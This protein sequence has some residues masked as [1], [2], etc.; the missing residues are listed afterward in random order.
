MAT[1][2]AR[3]THS[4]SG[5]Y[6]IE[7]EV[8]SGG[9]ATVYLAH[10]VR[11][12][13]RVALKVLRSE[14]AAVI[15]AERFLHEIKTTANLQHPHILALFDSGEVDGTVFYVMPYVEGESL[16]DRLNRE[17]QLPVDEA[18]RIAREVADALDYAHRHGVVHR[19]IKP[20]NI[21]LH[22][23]R[24]V[25][26]DFG[27]ALAVSRSD[28]A[29]R[30]TETG[31]SL[32]T[33]H[34]MSPEQ[35]MG[36]REVTSRSDV[37]A[38]GCVLYEMLV[39]EPPF[40]GPSAQAIV[41]RVVTE[42][43]RSLT[44][45]RHTIPPHVDAAVRR[46]LEKLP[47]DRFKSSAQFAEAL[48]NPS[49]GGSAAHAPASH[50]SSGGVLSRII[51]NP[52]WSWGTAMA[53]AAAAIALAT[54]GVL[55]RGP[56]PTLRFDVTL[57][58]ASGFTGSTVVLVSPD[59]RSVITR[60]IVGQR[61]ILIARRLD[62]L[63]ST[64]IPGSIGAERPFLSPDGASI[65]YSVNG[66][67]V[68]LPISGGTPVP[69]GETTWGGGA[70]NSDG[71][72]AFTK[73]YQSGLFLLNEAGGAERK[74]TDP[75]SSKGELAHWWPQWLP[76]G[77]SL[78]FTAYRSPISRA[79]IEVLDV[80]SGARKVI[81]EGGSMPKLLPTG[82]LLFVRDETVLAVGFDAKK[83]ETVG[84]PTVVVEDVFMNFSD[85][86]ASWD[87]SPNG[88]L[89]YIAA[90]S[91]GSRVSV[92]EVDRRGNER[93]VIDV[94]DRYT[95]PRWAPDGRRISVTHAAQRSAQD[96]WVY[97]PA[98]ANRVRITS[99]EGQD[100][101]A[102]WSPDGRELIFMSER[103]LFELHRKSSDASRPSAPF[104]GGQHDR[105]TG[106]V[107][108]DGILAFVL[109]APGA[110]EIWTAPLGDA[111]RATKYLTTGFTLGHPALAPTGRWM[112]YDSNEGGRLEVFIQSYPDPTRD[113]IQVSSGGGSEPWWT[114]GGRELAFRRG[115]SVM[116]VSVD[117]LTGAA[118]RPIALFG[119]RYASR[120]DWAVPASYDVT[121]D[122][123]RFL[124]LKFAAGEER[125]RV[126]VVTNWFAELRSKV[127]R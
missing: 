75:D 68:K 23:G 119:G 2:L 96:V 62:S 65:A 117:P 40:T 95:E 32:G 106:N 102:V 70:W 8:G 44:G 14:L 113:R 5:R 58:Q 120:E 51:R 115:D 69:F 3:L 53:L 80:E 6:R 116:V 125:R 77:K 36:E 122:G 39:G 108:P 124:M 86:H 66:K 127:P 4:L 71:R 63:R 92:V 73:S 110:T 54:R 46:A 42:S 7:R 43:P 31:M 90:S 19:D 60:A 22:D 48:V 35:A 109:A 82:H 94:P 27:I 57:D 112:A 61:P 30:M 47:A 1:D 15:G 49:S 87:V 55:E 9:M 99:E 34:Y 88:T 100:F 83:L 72:I 18:V 45:Q 114:K 107:S 79:T 101:G 25:V 81:I 38:L 103:P 52:W 50:R 59:G 24:A 78:L 98:R 11:H 16:R 93:A 64:V 67:L 37:Y 12:E 104:I 91:A 26:A 20:E 89:A 84:S 105:V 17:T 121:P 56:M 28:S 74:L 13:R 21:L 126:N 97:D 111:G 85:G 33:P 123:E 41:A 29:S 10:D 76:D 118:G